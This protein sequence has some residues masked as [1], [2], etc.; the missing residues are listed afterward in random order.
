MLQTDHVHQPNGRASVLVIAPDV[1]GSKVA[2][3]GMRFLAIAR[4][5]AGH[6]DVTFAVGI[7][8][9]DLPEM[10][11]RIRVARYTDAAGLEDLVRSSDVVFCQ[12][13]D[14]NVLRATVGSGPKFIFDLYNVLPAE[15]IGAQRISGFDTAP[16]KDRAFGEVIDYFRLCVQAGSYFVTSNDRQRDF[17]AGYLLASNA[18]RPSD[19]DGR[20]VEQVIGLLPF[21]MD[22]EEPFQREHGLRGN[23][24]I[25]PDSVVLLWC[26]G[27]WDW[28]DA[29]TP[30]RAMHRLRDS[31]PDAHLVFYGT[32]H[33]NP[34]VGRPRNVDAARALAGE[35]GLLGESVHFIDGWIPA[36][37]RADYLLD[38]DIAISAHL[39]SFET[40]YAF[41]TRVLDHFWARLPSLVTGGDW[42]ADYIE[43]HGL[44]IV[45]PC[46]DVDAMT[47]AIARLVDDPA[48]RVRITQNIAGIREDW[49]WR[50]TTRELVAVVDARDSTLRNRSI[51]AAA[52]PPSSPALDP[53]PLRVP[54]GA[55]ERLAA[56][57]VGRVVRGVRRRLQRATRR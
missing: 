31:H 40:R 46:R 26:G 54:V 57:P 32:V 27:I 35:L 24:G 42:F 12:F 37:R 30:I 41:R 3:P 49:R 5:L 38:A 8:D 29:E 23:L 10:D 20:T 56:G 1:V 9:S 45:V 19:L 25:G 17:W 13:I 14:S 21:G 55:R 16:E 34:A 52:A 4:E 50:T 15:A 47:N 39:E 28:F 6:N 2:G 11:E 48:E 53:E 51:E 7:A 18:L 36:A 22:D 43:D 44:G 33:P